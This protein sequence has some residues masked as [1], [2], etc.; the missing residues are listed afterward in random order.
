MTV[1]GSNVSST[2]EGGEDNHSGYYYIPV[3]TLVTVSEN[4]QSITY[5]ILGLDGTLV[6]DGQLIMEL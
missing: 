4:K 5:G 6:I 1:I 3:S 2:A